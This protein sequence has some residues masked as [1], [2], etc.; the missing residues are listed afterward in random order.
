[1]GQGCFEVILR[2]FAMKA[3]VFFKFLLIK[4]LRRPSCKQ[5]SVSGISSSRGSFSGSIPVSKWLITM[6][7]VVVP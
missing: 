3:L 5:V 1:M 7:I 6:V 2:Y 4:L